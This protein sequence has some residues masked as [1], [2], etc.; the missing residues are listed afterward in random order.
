[1]SDCKKCV[2]QIVCKY[3]DGHNLYC[4]EDYECPHFFEV[5]RCENCKR[6]DSLYDM[7]TGRKL[8]YGVCKLYSSAF[9]R[10]EVDCEHFCGYGKRRSDNE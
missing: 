9:N 1:M 2:S 8:S 5:V 7:R 10:E 6:F 4:K 3:N